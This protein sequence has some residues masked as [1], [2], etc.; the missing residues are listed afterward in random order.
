MP[1]TFL[2][3]NGTPGQPYLFA[4]KLE[5]KGVGI[6]TQLHATGPGKRYNF[7]AKVVPAIPADVNQ[8]NVVWIYRHDRHYP[9]I[10]LTAG[11]VKAEFTWDATTNP[12][13]VFFTNQSIGATSFLWDFGGQG[14]S[15]LLNPEFMFSFVG[16]IATFVVSLT[17]N[18][19]ADTVMHLVE[20][21]QITA[22]LL[23]S[24]DT[25]TMSEL[26]TLTTHQLD[27]LPVIS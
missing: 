1:T 20:I 6:W 12:P 23:L 14:S 24:L 15:V 18:G 17:I 5:L 21:S 16:P 9:A 19:G 10:Q 3:P 7:V 27:I 25:L 11:A 13:T 22:G 8:K 26:N 2:S 4:S